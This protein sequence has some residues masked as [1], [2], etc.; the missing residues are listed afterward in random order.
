MFSSFKP[1]SSLSSSSAHDG[2]NSAVQGLQGASLPRLDRTV[3]VLSDVSRQGRKSLDFVIKALVTSPEVRSSVLAAI[4]EH[5]SLLESPKRRAAI[6]EALTPLSH[7]DAV[8]ELAVVS[9]ESP[10]LKA[11]ARTVSAACAILK[12]AL[13]ALDEEEPSVLFPLQLERRILKVAARYSPG[14]GDTAAGAAILLLRETPL[15]TRMQDSVRSLARDWFLARNQ[16]KNPW[17]AL[18]SEMPSKEN[19]AFIASLASGRLPGPGLASFLRSLVR[20]PVTFHEVAITSTIVTVASRQ[21]CAYFKL[22]K[23]VSN[24]AIAAI[25]VGLV[26]GSRSLAHAFQED[27]I[28]KSRT[29]ERVEGIALLSAMRAALGD[30]PSSAARF[31]VLKIVSAL[32]KA[33]RSLMQPPFVRQ[34]ATIALSGEVL[35]PVDLWNQTVISG[36]FGEV[37]RQTHQAVRL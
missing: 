29:W 26:V 34:A 17:L 16:G 14:G 23:V 28:N 36:D 1:N 30:D 13:S 2:L 32:E 10:Y 19:V 25:S 9:L 8:C 5:P 24:A 6:L 20:I 31:S 33:S 22:P 7:E 37:L 18:L 15:G 11:S 21:I 3:E 35:D 4:N 12:P 27:A